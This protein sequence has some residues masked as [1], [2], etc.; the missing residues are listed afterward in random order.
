MGRP[1]AEATRDRALDLGEER[2]LGS[3]VVRCRS[4]GVCLSAAFIIPFELKW[5]SLI[6]NNWK[7]FHRGAK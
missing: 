6:W 1:R 2:A 5:Q 7:L 3:K 4:N